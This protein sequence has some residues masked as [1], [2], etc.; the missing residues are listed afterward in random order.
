M[1][2]H[3][4]GIYSSTT[5]GIWIAKPGLEHMKRMETAKKIE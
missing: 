2:L 1:S 4:G 5:P 3:T